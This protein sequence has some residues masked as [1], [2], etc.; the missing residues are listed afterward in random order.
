MHDKGFAHRDLK[1]QNIIY[2]E[3]ADV[4]DVDNE[5]KTVKGEFL[6]IDF[7][8]SRRVGEELL[9]KDN[10]HSDFLDKDVPYKIEHEISNFGNL[11]EDLESK[12]LDLVDERILT[13]VPKLKDNSMTLHAFI[14]ELKKIRE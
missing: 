7:D 4:I 5:K 13:L 14:C 8:H 12:K 6:L 3:S 11:I 2:D 1:L 10:K 9:S